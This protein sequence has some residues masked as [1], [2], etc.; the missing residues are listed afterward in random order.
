MTYLF[1]IYLVYL[2]LAGSQGKDTDK[3][4]LFIFLGP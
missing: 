4:L 1:E 3:A 2:S